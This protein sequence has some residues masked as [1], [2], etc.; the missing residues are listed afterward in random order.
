M[1]NGAPSRFVTEDHPNRHNFVDNCLYT[2]GPT[3]GRDAACMICLELMTEEDKTVTHGL[4]HA[5]ECNY[6]FHLSCFDGL[7]AN[8]DLADEID[9]QGSN[10]GDDKFAKCPMC[11]GSL[12]PYPKQGCALPPAL[13]AERERAR[14]EAARQRAMNETWMGEAIENDRPFTHLEE[15]IFEPRSPGEPGYID[16]LVM[17]PRSYATAVEMNVDMDMDVLL[18]TPRTHLAAVDT[19]MDM[20]IDLLVL[21]PDPPLDQVQ[22]A[23]RYMEALF[24]TNGRR[25]S[26]P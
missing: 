12:L 10:T 20:D 17:T 4:P 26:A 11:R 5:G 3:P 16:V 6:A 1:S 22:E 23:V 7:V 19:G 13:I 21:D 24:R 8:T 2:Q 25:H 18:F 9:P 14:F 15:L